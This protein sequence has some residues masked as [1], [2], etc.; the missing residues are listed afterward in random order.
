ML[1]KCLASMSAQLAV[2]TIKR[3][4]WPATIVDLDGAFRA[5]ARMLGQQPVARRTPDAAE[6]AS[7]VWPGCRAPGW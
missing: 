2:D 7:D 3:K 5:R 1:G 4:G 6:T